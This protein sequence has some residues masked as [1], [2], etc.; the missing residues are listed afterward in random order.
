MH[1]SWS[2]SSSALKNGK[3]FQNI[4]KPEAPQAPWSRLEEKLISFFLR[5]LSRLLA[6]KMPFFNPLSR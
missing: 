4:E 2:E 1:P 6:A 3:A 5:R